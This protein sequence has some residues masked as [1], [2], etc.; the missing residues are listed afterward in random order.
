MCRHIYTVTPNKSLETCTLSPFFGFGVHFPVLK[1]GLLVVV[2]SF[3]D[4]GVRKCIQNQARWRR[5]IIQEL[6]T[7]TLRREV[8]GQPSSGGS[9]VGRLEHPLMVY[10]DDLVVPP[11]P[12]LFRNPF[13]EVFI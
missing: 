8:F 1:L 12:P 13:V 4:G 5:S 11:V 9:G 3:W 7:Y 2:S 6:E 10:V